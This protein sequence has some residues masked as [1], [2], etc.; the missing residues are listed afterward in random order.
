MYIGAPVVDKTGL[1][2]VYEY[3]FVMPNFVGG[4]QRG[5]PGEPQPAAPALD[6]AGAWSAALEAQLGL[7]LQA[8]KAVPTQRLVI[9]H[10]ELPT[11]N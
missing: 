11:P 3:E 2:G 7:R 9:D 10:V 8:E 6:R 1:S 4:G 5:A